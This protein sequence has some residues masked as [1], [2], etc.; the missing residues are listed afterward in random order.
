MNSCK[1][2]E[3]DYPIRCG[4]RQAPVASKETDIDGLPIALIRPQRLADLNMMIG[5]ANHP[6][7]TPRYTEPERCRSGTSS[8][9]TNL[10][11]QIGRLNSICKPFQAI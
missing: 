4:Y 6:S 5:T 8:T 2:L 10:Y 3:K 7:P 1:V 11:A 9:G